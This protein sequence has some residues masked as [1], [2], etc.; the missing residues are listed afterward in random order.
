M[1]TEISKFAITQNH[2]LT[3]ALPK[4]PATP[5]TPTDF[6]LLY[7]PNWGYLHCSTK[8]Y[9]QSTNPTDFQQ[10]CYGI[11]DTVLKGS[12]HLRYSTNSPLWASKIEMILEGKQFVTWKGVR[13]E[14]VRGEKMLCKQT[15]II[16][17]SI[18]NE[19]EEIIT[20]DLPFEFPLPNNLPATI[21]PLNVIEYG[22]NIAGGVAGDGSE[23]GHITYILR[24][25]ITRPINI[26]KLRMNSKKIIDIWCRIHRWQSPPLNDRPFKWNGNFMGIG[27]EVE[28]EKTLF[29]YKDII[30]IP[31]KF[32]VNDLTNVKIKKI[33]VRIKEYHKLKFNGKSNTIGGFVVADSS[34]GEQMRK[35]NSG[36]D[37]YYFIKMQLNLTKANLGRK[38]NCSMNTEYIDIR[39]KLKIKITLSSSSKNIELDKEI[40]ILNVFAKRDH[41]CFTQQCRLVNTWFYHLHEENLSKATMSEVRDTSNLDKARQRFSWF[42]GMK[43]DR[44]S[45]FSNS[46]RQSHAF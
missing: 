28:L 24:A 32:F 20:L 43:N 16:W 4:R 10:G 6:T 15:K 44:F 23:V 2:L 17:E 25:E 33:Y 19:F 37:H 38:L 3:D 36:K 46:N 14:V 41:P 42:G 45:F 18:N 39:H 29:N 35:S 30:N 7:N 12:F 13:G 9:F 40:S 27:Y 8:A 26:F 22:G 5:T 1:T 11:E 31:M 21:T 34:F